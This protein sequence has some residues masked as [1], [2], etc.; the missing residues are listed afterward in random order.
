LCQNSKLIKNKLKLIGNNLFSVS[1]SSIKNTKIKKEEIKLIHP[2]NGYYFTAC[3]DIEINN[4]TFFTI[5][6]MNKFS[7]R[8]INSSNLFIFTSNEERELFLI[9]IKEKSGVEEFSEKY[10]LICNL[11]H[12]HFGKVKLGKNR[13]TQSEVAVKIINKSKLKDD[14]FQQMVNSEIEILNFIKNNPHPNLVEI[15]DIMEDKNYIYFVMEYLKGGSLQN[16][17]NIKA[18][19]IQNNV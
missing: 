15:Y 16:Y 1:S 8:I 12:G 13:K 6:C 7:S 4:K 14:K 9:K 3:E 19:I 2:L 5:G 10:E 17:L 11:S 18:L